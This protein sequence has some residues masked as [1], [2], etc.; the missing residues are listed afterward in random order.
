M[1]FRSVLVILTNLLA[2][3]WKYSSKKDFASIEFGQQQKGQVMTFYVSDNGAGFDM[4]YAKDLFNAFHRLHTEKEFPG[5]G[6]GL[7][8]VQRIIHR[9]GGSIWAESEIGKGAT[10]FFTLGCVDEL[11]S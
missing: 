11:T 9:H 6:I 7:A 1:L 8:T 10:F 4:Q 3:A 5:T 2:N